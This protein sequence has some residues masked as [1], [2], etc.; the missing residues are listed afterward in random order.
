MNEL[1][2]IEHRQIDGLS[3]FFD[4]IDY[5]TPHVHPEWELIW[6]LDHPLVVTCSQNQFLVQPEQMVLFSPN[7]PHEFHKKENS[8]TFIC[9]QI[10]S[11]ILPALPNMK[12]DEKLPHEY[13][14]EQEL[15]QLKDSVLNIL[16]AYLHR[17][18]HYGL[19]CVG[20]SCMVLHQLL[21]R[22]PSHIL[23]AEETA[24]VNKRNAR[25][26]RLIHFVDENY[27]HKI[28]LADFAKAEGCSMSYL[29][30]FIKET[31]NQNFQDYVKSM[32]FN[33]ACKL[34]AAGGKRMLD[35]C[36]E[37]GFSDYRYFSRAFQQQ[38]GMTPE[39]YSHYAQKLQ[40]ETSSVRHSLHSV[41]RFYTREESL[42][43]VDK[44]F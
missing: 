6:V 13:L 24:S 38:Y 11:S 20:Q 32:R 18:A 21:T 44:L 7:E 14:S 26:Q 28:R 27:M 19:W 8:S 43:L 42:K 15:T 9:L 22:L 23:T 3:I 5:R 30:R 37:S 33:C 4:T 31:M 40:L 25:L 10:S 35:V 12:I 36:M 17:E 41:E 1:E 2:I 16:K 39:E 34:I 29:S